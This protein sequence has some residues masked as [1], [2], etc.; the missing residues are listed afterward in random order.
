M[1]I[2]LSKPALDQLEVTLIGPGYGECCIVHVGSNRWLIIDSC[3]D[4]SGQPA[5]LEYL[6]NIGVDAQE[7]VRWIIATHWHDDHVAGLAEV[8]RACKQARF[9]CSSALSKNE[10]IAI[11]TRFNEKASFDCS[12][13]V[14]ELIAVLEELGS[15]DRPHPSFAGPDRN[16]ETIDAS[17][18]AHAEECQ[19]W[20]LSPS[21]AQ[22]HK[23]L[24]EIA[25]LVP[26]LGETSRRF[27]SQPTN[28]LAVVTF[29]RIGSLGM[30][31]GADLE[32]T[33]DPATGWSPI[34][35]SPGRPKLKSSVFKV[36]HHGSENGHSEL[37]WEQMLHAKPVAL[38]TPYNRGRKPLPCEEDVRRI[39]SLSGSFYLTS[40]LSKSPKRRASAVEKM[41]AQVG[42][43]QPISNIPGIV[44]LRNGGM[45]NPNAWVAE[46]SSEAR[47]MDIPA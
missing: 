24:R 31:F 35:A 43:L 9:F 44:R 33:A 32:E 8:L 38:T 7:A 1:G 11:V 12:S 3:R 10:F 13:G 5:A 42:R 15:S 41:I 20:T 21:D 26:A 45:D 47:Q 28:Y 40:V 19:I 27:P 36:P 4:S 46:L 23:F 34:V 30:L 37:V 22:L 17:E 16:L 14:S 29:V 39:A 2:T 6:Q 18:L 25:G